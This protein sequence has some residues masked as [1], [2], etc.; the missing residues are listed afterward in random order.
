MKFLSISLPLFPFLSPRSPPTHLFLS[1]LSSFFV[2]Q[3][4]LQLMDTCC[5]EAISFN[6]SLIHPTSLR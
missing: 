5:L 3:N 1:S 6:S 4:G 2:H